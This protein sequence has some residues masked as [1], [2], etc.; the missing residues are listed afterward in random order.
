MIPRY[1]RNTMGNLWGQEY[2]L[3]TWLHVEI[4][5]CEAWAETGVVSRNVVQELRTQ[6]RI[7]SDRMEEWEKK[8]HHD[9]TAFLHAVS[10]TVSPEAARWLHYGLTSTDLVDTA[11]GYLLKKANQQ[12]LKGI[13]QLM[14]TLLALAQRYR[15][16]PTIG[17][18]HGMYAEPVT[19]GWKFARW[20]IEMQRN[21]ER[22][23]QASADVEVGKL[24]GAV[25]TYATVEPTVE[26]YVCQKLGL[27]PAVWST[28]IVSR[29]R[30]AHYVNI[31]A[32]IATSLEN[33]ATEIRHLQRSEVGEVSESFA[34]TQTG[35]SAMPHKR[36]PI[37]CE[38]LCGL[39]RLLRGYCL[40]SYENMIS[41]HE[42]DI[43][44]S[45]VERVLL[46]DATQLLDTMLYRLND[47]LR[48]LVLDTPKMRE[49]LAN[50]G[51][52]PFS[53][54]VLLALIRKG[55][56][57]V[58]AYDLVRSLAHRAQRGEMDFSTLVQNDPLIRRS[59]TQS[60]LETCF[61]IQNHLQSIDSL[62]RRSNL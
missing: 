50:A 48:N 37:G 3:Q 2:R 39:A 16:T 9:V 7:D 24:S 26:A 20:Y 1:V 4:L 22:F 42:R 49:L 21:R 14:E 41:W 55:W 33:F 27:T 34:P 36:N 19:L 61:D 28:Q 23:V 54:R 51:G 40:P 5:V 30:H 11:Q 60:E 43:S 15:A 25:G 47:I 18:T 57:R 38:N 53:H 46:P 58:E 32:L 45:S 44:H 62:F 52:E 35:S 8:T 17:R 56:T 59:L 6:A 13:S 31:L 29:D 12:L 10:E